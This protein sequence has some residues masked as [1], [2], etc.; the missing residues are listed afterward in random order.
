MD[1][2][3]RIAGIVIRRLEFE[4]F[5]PETFPQ[6]DVLFAPL[7]GGGLGLDSLA[8]LE[9]IAGL[10]SELGLPFDDV[11]DADLRS[12]TALAAYVERCGGPTR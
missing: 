9:I 8:S 5:T 3:H 2:R 10:S 12:T 11:S 6:G 1:L 7:D 4:G